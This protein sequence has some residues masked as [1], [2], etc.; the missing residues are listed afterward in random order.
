MPSAVTKPLR[1]RFPDP[2]DITYASLAAAF[3]QPLEHHAEALRRMAELVRHRADMANQTA[4]QRAARE[5]MALFPAGAEVLFIAPDVWVVSS[6]FSSFPGSSAEMIDVI[7]ALALGTPRNSRWSDW[8][9]SCASSPASQDSS[10][11]CSTGSC[12]IYPSHRPA[13]A[14]SANKSLHRECLF[15]RPSEPLVQI[16]T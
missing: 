7:H 8:K 9:A 2:L 15:P 14:P 1:G 13:S 11:A 4:E 12:R 5:R 16:V 6:R 3:G 10:S